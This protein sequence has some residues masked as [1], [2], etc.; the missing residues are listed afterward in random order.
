MADQASEQANRAGMSPG[1]LVV[2]FY[3]GA[4]LVLSLFLWKV[5]AQVWPFGDSNDAL[6]SVG[7]SVT[8]VAGTV[9]AAGI[10]IGC[11]M[12]PRTKGLSYEVATEL[13]KVTWP[14]W[15]ETRTSTTAVVV[16]SLV[17]AV[18]L[19]GIDSAAYKLMVDWLPVLWGK[20]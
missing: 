15:E 10:A 19:F 2:I 4:G 3:L 9:L 18:V 17:A 13:M 5:L 11:Y 16:A 1:R 6:E 7:L 14:S 20:F 12:H 8:Q